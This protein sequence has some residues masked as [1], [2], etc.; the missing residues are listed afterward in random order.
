[1]SKPLCISGLFVLRASIGEY[2]FFVLFLYNYMHQ[3]LLL[4]MLQAVCV[5]LGAAST[6]TEAE[7][8]QLCVCCDDLRDPRQAGSDV[9]GRAQLGDWWQRTM[10]GTP[11]SALTDDS[12]LEIVSR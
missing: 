1:M 8:A 5:C 7:I 10:A 11:H 4:N 9:T 2:V 3:V 6:C 12:Y